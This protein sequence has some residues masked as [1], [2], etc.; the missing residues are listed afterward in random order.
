MEPAAMQRVADELEIRNLIAQIFHLSDFA[1]DL[2][3]YL[4][5]FTEDAVW[6]TAREAA[7]AGAHT[8]SRLVGRAALERDRTQVRADRHQGPG[9]HTWHVITNLVVRVGDDDT[10]EADSY[11]VWIVE[12]DVAPRVAAIGRYQDQFRRTDTGWKLAHRRFGVDLIRSR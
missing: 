2:T 3:E 9:T 8:S 12:A 5:C 11:Y 1:P 10:A 6:E 4:E 7:S